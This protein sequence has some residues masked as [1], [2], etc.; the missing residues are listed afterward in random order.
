MDGEGGPDLV[1][2]EAEVVAGGETVEDGVGL[3]GVGAG[4]VAVQEEGDD[5]VG[6]G[7][8]PGGRAAGLGRRS[9]LDL[10]AVLRDQSILLLVA[11]Q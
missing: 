7:E 11:E 8:G 4:V 3:G 9:G 10:G 1:G 6:H 5:G 2:G